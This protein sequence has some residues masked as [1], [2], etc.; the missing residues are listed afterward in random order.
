MDELMEYVNSKSGYS[1]TVR[2]GTLDDYARV[3]T[4]T[5]HDSKYCHHTQECTHTHTHA[6]MYTHLHMHTLL[7][8]VMS[9]LMPTG[10]YSIAPGAD[11]R[12]PIK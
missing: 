2:Y 10:T 11:I 9:W 7:F 6:R 3:L 1:V 4:C 8:K 5:K 12:S